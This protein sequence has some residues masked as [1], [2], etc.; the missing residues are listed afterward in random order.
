MAKI[1]ADYIL[2]KTDLD[3]SICIAGYNCKNFIF[4]CLESIF[5]SGE[6]PG[7]T[8][9]EATTPVNFEVIYI[10]DAST[11]GSFDYVRENFTR[12][13]CVS[14]PAN[15]G[16]SRTNNNGINLSQGRYIL[17]LN[18]DTCLR[19]GVLSSLVVFM[20]SQ[21]EAGA[22]GPQLLNQD[23][24][25]Q[26]SG[27]PFPTPF[28][29]FLSMLPLKTEWFSKSKRDYNKVSIVDEVSGAALLLRFSVLQ[30]VGLLDENFY[31]Y[32]EDVDLCFRIKQA[33]YKV[34]YVPTSKIVHYGGQS[35]H[36]LGLRRQLET[37]W[38]AYYY[39]RKHFGWWGGFC[40]TSLFLVRDFL[41]LSVRVFIMII[42]LIKQKT[43]FVSED[44][45]ALDE[46]KINLKITEAI[47]RLNFSRA[48]W[49]IGV[50]A[51]GERKG[52]SSF[53]G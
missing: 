46:A 49:P 8:F 51:K 9:E 31:L 27:R 7:I 21:P 14:N 26:P 38:S 15:L 24:T 40:S 20:D 10:D 52:F 36:Q 44:N 16:Y 50:S 6:I 1:S 45:S 37:L 42:L 48:Y 22:A 18:A 5:I 13:R 11:D 17:L 4:Q 12:V 41:L 28:R 19:P 43:G 33:G 2:R 32:Y 25:L 35:T 23:G 3:L 53:S 29:L 47:K 39:F 34:Y 30:E